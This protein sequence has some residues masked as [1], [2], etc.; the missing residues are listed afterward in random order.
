[1]RR[2]IREDEVVGLPV[3]FRF[4]YQG[5]GA[6][7]TEKQEMRYLAR[8]CLVRPPPDASGKTALPALQIK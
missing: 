8:D 5:T 6:P 2:Q 3:K 1:M 4:L 7:I